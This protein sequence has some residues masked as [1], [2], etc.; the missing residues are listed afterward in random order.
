VQF[1]RSNARVIATY[2][3]TRVTVATRETALDDRS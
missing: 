2:E 3:G 1:S